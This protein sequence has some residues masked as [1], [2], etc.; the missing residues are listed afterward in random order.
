L[1]EERT[2]DA[3]V[4]GF[5]RAATGAQTW[6]Q[7]LDAVQAAFS[8]RTVLMHT[9]DARNGQ[10]VRM[11]HGGPS[12]DDGVL[13]Y[14]REYHRCDPRRDR[15][16]ARMPDIIGQWW[17]CHE[18]L[19]E[20]F[21]AGQ[22][23]YTEFL[24]AYDT[25][26][27]STIVL[28]PSEP[29][30]TVFT[31]LAIELP[32]AR[33]VLTPDEREWARRLADHLRDALHAYKRL[34]SLLSQALAGHNLLHRF[35]YPMWLMDEQRSIAFENEAATREQTQA[36]R[37]V[38]RGAHLWLVKDRS[39]QQLTERLHG[40]CRAGHGA[41]TVVDLRATEADAPTWLHLS[42]LVPEA[43]LGAFGEQPQILATL[44]DPQ[45]VSPLDPFALA[46]MFRLTPT[47]AK[48]AARLADGLT[49]DQIG[50]AHGTATSTVRSQVR[51]VMAKLGAKRTADVVRM[52]RQGEALWAGAAAVV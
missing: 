33:G 23:F 29:E 27:L 8:A 47:E 14:V 37:V 42:L 25:R 6:D 46:N 30:Q 51:Q 21:V 19:D 50:V 24:P 31:A 28:A 1:V 2:F 17:H 12:M 39:N 35:A 48:V 34:R 36:H 7:A 49:A 38:R 44:F 4:A 3:V 10:I 20:E 40:L 41:S 26:Y 32:A 9:A 15:I 13:E 16:L 22:R 52:L 45:H 11:N 5:Y 43:V 18:H